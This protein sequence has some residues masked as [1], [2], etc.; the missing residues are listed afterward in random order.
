MDNI[1]QIKSVNYM[2]VVSNID[3]MEV[4]RSLMRDPRYKYLKEE[5]RNGDIEKIGEKF[6]VRMI[7]TYIPGLKSVIIEYLIRLRA[8]GRK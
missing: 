8:V 3:I 4:Y 5:L 6:K 1:N 7:N 2:P